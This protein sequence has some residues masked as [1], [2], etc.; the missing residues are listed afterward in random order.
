MEKTDEYKIKVFKITDKSLKKLGELLANE[1]SRNIILLLV[2]E[3]L[4]V[5]QIAERLQLRVSLVIH[6]LQKLEELKLLD[7]VEKPISR[8]TKNHR[9]FRMSTDI[10]LGGIG[11]TEVKKIFKEGIKFSALSLFTF[12]LASHIL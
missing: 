1:T 10:F 8:R 12:F 7:V 3:E 4:Y 5:N 2:E 11:K 6:H 9:F